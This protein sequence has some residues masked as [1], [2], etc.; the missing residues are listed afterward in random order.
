MAELRLRKSKRGKNHLQSK[1]TGKTESERRKAAKF[2][3]KDLGVIL[4][5]S[6]YSNAVIEKRYTNYYPK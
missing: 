1:R 6:S 2:Q 3:G 4:F 5:A